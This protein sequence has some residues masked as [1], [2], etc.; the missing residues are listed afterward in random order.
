MPDRFRKTLVGDN[1]LIYDSFED[2]DYSLNCGG[3]IVF[4]TRANLEILFKSSILHVDGTFEVTPLIFFQLFSIMGT[5]TQTYK[6]IERKVAIPLVHSLLESKREEAY[7]K[8]LEVTL[9]YAE[10][11]GIRIN[12]H[13]TVMS[14][15]EIAII[16]ATKTHFGEDVI[17]LCLFHLCQSVYRHVQSTGL[18]QQ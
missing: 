6:G 12:F 15:F 16:N 17:R 18:Q 11:A 8:V 9:A 4:G 13:Q 10:N 2:E 1:F 7:T 5:I 3:I 14:D